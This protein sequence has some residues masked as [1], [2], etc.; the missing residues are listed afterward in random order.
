MKFLYCCFQYDN[1]MIFLYIFFDSKIATLT[2]RSGPEWT[3]RFN[4]KK[5]NNPSIKLPRYDGCEF[6]VEDYI[7][8][9]V[10]FY[11]IKIFFLVIEKLMLGFNDNIK[12]KLFFNAK[13]GENF[14]L[15]GI[16]ILMDRKKKKLCIV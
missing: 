7:R 14:K 2:Y 3:E 1:F 13:S 12:K 6:L 15:M 11:F 4:T 5:I 8:H 10:I 16:F 9:Q